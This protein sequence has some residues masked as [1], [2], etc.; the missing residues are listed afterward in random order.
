MHTRNFVP[1]VESHTFLELNSALS[2]DGSEQRGCKVVVCS[3]MG[4]LAFSQCL[5]LPCFPQVGKLQSM[6]R[7]RPVLE[8]VMLAA[9]IVMQ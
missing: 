8:R 1:A 2:T 4:H 6:Y 5:A 3:I 9:G 7:V